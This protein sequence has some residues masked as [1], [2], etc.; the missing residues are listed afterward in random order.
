MITTIDIIED[1][2]R[3]YARARRELA[4]RVT[5]LEDEMLRV[6]RSRMRGIKN[7]L[8]AAQDAQAH[9]RAAIEAAPELF[10]KPRTITIDGVKVGWMKAPGRIVWE[11]DEAVCRQ[12]RKHFP[13]SADALIKITEKPIRAALNNL[14][15]AELRKIGCTTDEAGDAIVIKP[16]DSEVDKLVD[17]LLKEDVE[18]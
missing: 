11:D 5:A 16:Q 15:V 1:L 18:V 2:T 3:G 6:K 7:A 13:D 9:V 14:T 12:I 4:E 10:I 17:R 8:A